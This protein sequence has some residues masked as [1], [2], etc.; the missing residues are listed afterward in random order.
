M[1]RREFAINSRIFY[2]LSRTLKPA[3]WNR[4]LAVAEPRASAV[5]E[6]F[7]IQ[8]RYERIRVKK[9]RP[10]REK[11]ASGDHAATA[12]GSK[13]T[14]PTCSNR[15]LIVQYAIA[16]PMLTPT[17]AIAPLFPATNANGSEISAMISANSGT[18]NFR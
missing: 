1:D 9:Y 18:A 17:P 5:A 2:K 13:L 8:L 11:R 3:M 4:S 6:F 15:A 14:L 16:M 10:A 7:S 12:A